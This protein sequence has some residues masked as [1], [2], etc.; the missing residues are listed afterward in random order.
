MALCGPTRATG[1]PAGAPRARAGFAPE[2]GHGPYMGGVSPRP[3][4]PNAPIDFVGIQMG[5]RLIG[6]QELS[7]PKPLIALTLCDRGD[8]QANTGPSSGRARWL[9]WPRWQAGWI[10]GS[11]RHQTRWATPATRATWRQRT[12]ATSG[13]RWP[14]FLRPCRRAAGSVNHLLTLDDLTHWP[15][16]VTVIPGNDARGV[17]QHDDHQSNTR[18]IR[19]HCLR[20]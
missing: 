19:A 7:P 17:E 14:I 4:W 9:M 5:R 10:A 13:P 6:Y 1:T 2:G 20:D 18:A 11:A 16:W 12:A 3:E 15:W 8:A